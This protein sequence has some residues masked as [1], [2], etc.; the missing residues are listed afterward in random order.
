MAVCPYCGHPWGQLASGQVY[1]CPSCGGHRVA[2]SAYRND[3]L[4]HQVVSILRT[5]DVIVTH[6]ETANSTRGGGQTIKLMLAVV[7]HNKSASSGALIA[8]AIGL[9]DRHSIVDDMT[10]IIARLLEQQDEEV[11]TLRPIDRPDKKLCI[12]PGAD[13]E[14]P[15]LAFYLEDKKP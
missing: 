12:E 14:G 11:V 6:I 7:G 1:P 15:Y 13:A 10:R 5:L 8:E 2:S 3:P 9:T 4:T